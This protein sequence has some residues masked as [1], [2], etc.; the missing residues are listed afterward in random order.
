ML[1]ICEKVTEIGM[2][3]IIIILTYMLVWLLAFIVSQ[4]TH[5]PESSSVN[6][7]LQNN[8]IHNTISKYTF[9]K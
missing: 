9:L 2:C 6:R 7:Q 1:S 3:L 8:I 4:I 5:D